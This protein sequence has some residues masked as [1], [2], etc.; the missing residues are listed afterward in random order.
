M[1]R[2]SIKEY[3][4][5]VSICFACKYNTAC[6]FKFDYVNGKDCLVKEYIDKRGIK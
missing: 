6:K 2:L 4:E 5:R 3:N 1:K